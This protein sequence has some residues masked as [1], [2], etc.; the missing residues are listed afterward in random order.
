MERVKYAALRRSPLEVLLFVTLSNDIES[1]FISAQH[2]HSLN[3]GLSVERIHALID[4]AT[5]ETADKTT[6]AIVNLRTEEA[7][8]RRQGGQAP[9]H[10]QIAVQAQ[11][12]YANNPSQYRRGKFVLGRLAALLQQEIGQNPRIFLPSPHLR[13]RHLTEIAR[14]IWPA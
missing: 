2:L 14:T 11:A 6:V 1:Y 4:Q 7:F 8:K 12:D 5:Q 3:P 10:G 9:N 13:D